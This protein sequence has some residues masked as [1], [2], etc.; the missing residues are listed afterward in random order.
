MRSKVPND[1]TAEKPG[2]AKNGYETIVH[3]RRSSN[4]STHL[5]RSRPSGLGHLNGSLPVAIRDEGSPDRSHPRRC[6]KALLFTF[7]ASA[8]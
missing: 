5:E 8:V 2:S 4:S 1:A 7:A 6:S 3:G